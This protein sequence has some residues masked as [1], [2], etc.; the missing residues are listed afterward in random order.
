MNRYLAFFSLFIKHILA[1]KTNFFWVLLFPL[2]LMIWNFNDWIHSRPGEDVYVQTMVLFWSL[3]I[4]MTATNGYATS[5]IMMRENGFLKFF[6]FVAGSKYTVVVGHLLSQI[7][8]LLVNITLFTLFTSFIFGFP[9][10]LWM[11][12][13]LIV[14]VTF[15]PVCLLFSWL[16]ILPYRQE[17]IT[18]IISVVVIL[19]VYSTQYLSSVS[20]KSFLMFVHPVQF[21]IQI[22]N[23]ILSVF[24]LPYESYGNPLYLVA[25]VIVY[26]FFGLMALKHMKVYS[27]TSRN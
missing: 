25:A 10:Y 1:Q 17:T 13:V 21:V 8:A 26:V 14:I 4:V 2:G 22:A 9:I 27:I 12:A 7:S 6:R 3:I 18:P 24:G 5:L 20:V 19:L 16:A 11:L 15:T 23:A